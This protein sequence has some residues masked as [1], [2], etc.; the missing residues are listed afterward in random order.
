[1]GADVVVDPAVASPYESW[2]ELAYGSPGPVRDMMGLLNAP[3]CVVFECVGVPGVLDSIILGC[4][5][6]TC[7]F[8]PAGRPRATTFT[9]WW[10]S[11]KASISNS[12]AAH[13]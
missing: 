4:E 11:A 3:S 12:V 1:M 5:R 2:R 6:G 9:P 7:I 13:P 8:P 10:P